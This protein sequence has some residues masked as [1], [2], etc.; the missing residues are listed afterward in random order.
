MNEF[1]SARWWLEYGAIVLG[2]AIGASLGIGMAQLIAAVTPLPAHSRA[3]TRV[4]LA[5]PALAEA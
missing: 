5:T 1:R 4:R 2:A 3:S